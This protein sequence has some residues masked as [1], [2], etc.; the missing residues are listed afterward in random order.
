M[1]AIQRKVDMCEVM[2]DKAMAH[3]LQTWMTNVY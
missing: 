3:R 2:T 1:Y